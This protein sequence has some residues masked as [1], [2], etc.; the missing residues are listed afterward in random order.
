MTS[1]CLSTF[2]NQPCLGP[3]GW[4]CCLVALRTFGRGQRRHGKQHGPTHPRSERFRQVT[5]RFLSSCTRI[6]SSR[7]KGNSHKAR[8]G[9]CDAWQRVPC[10]LPCQARDSIRRKHFPERIGFP[11]PCQRW[12]R[13]YMSFESDPRHLAPTFPTTPFLT[14]MLSLAKS[15]WVTQDSINSTTTSIGNQ[16]LTNMGFNIMGMRFLLLTWSLRYSDV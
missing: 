13:S 9:I 11:N 12:K 6:T 8:H 5:A 10:N 2:C 1:A 4:F 16:G 14:L 15:G 7:D 3:K